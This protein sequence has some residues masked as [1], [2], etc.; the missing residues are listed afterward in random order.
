MELQDAVILSLLFFV[1]AALYTT[2]GHAGASGYLAMMALVGLA[3]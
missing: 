2:V 3:P 1:V